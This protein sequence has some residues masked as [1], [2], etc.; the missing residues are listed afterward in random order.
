MKGTVSL[1]FFLNLSFVYRRAID[2]S[3]NFVFCYIAKS[4]PAVEF[5]WSF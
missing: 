3:V 4:L 2:F 5:S 1:A